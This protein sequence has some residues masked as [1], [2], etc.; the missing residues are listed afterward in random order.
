MQLTEL[1]LFN[2]R[3]FPPQQRLALKPGYNAL[4]GAPAPLRAA[5]Y[6]CLYP[7]PQ[8]S[9]LAA[10]SGAR[11]GVE[12][13]GKDGKPY[14]MLR[15]LSGVGATLSREDPPGQWPTVAA[16][17]ASLVRELVQL[18]AVPPP[19]FVAL[20]NLGEE[21]L[22]S[23][24]PGGGDTAGLQKQIADLQRELALAN[25]VENFGDR[26]FALEKRIQEIDQLLSGLHGREQQLQR[27]DD[28]L[29]VF[30]RFAKGLDQKVK[31]YPQALKIKD[32]GLQEIADQQADLAKDL[33]RTVPP[34]WQDRIFMAGAAAGALP[35]VMALVAGKGWLFADIPGF[36]AAAVGAWL[37]IMKMEQYDVL[38]ARKKQ[39]EDRAHRVLQ[40]WDADAGPV[41]AA[42]HALQI[43]TVQELGEQLK[44]R[45]NL[46]IERDSGAVLLEG[47]RRAPEM[48][49]LADE[50]ASGKDELTRMEARMARAGF[51]R[52][53]AEI[54]QDLV[55]LQAELQAAYSS[56]PPPED[57]LL[58]ACASFFGIQ[59]AQLGQAAG[60]RAAQFR[61]G[62]APVTGGPDAR[63]L[64]Y[65]ALKAALLE[66]AAQ[67]SK[68]P[69]LIEGSFYGAE[70][71][72]KHLST[73]TQVIQL[74]SQAPAGAENVIRIG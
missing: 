54:E 12:F 39:L 10:S 21:E 32:D 65:V 70:K 74:A 17:P 23:R 16:D 57:A 45:D 37:W 33:A 64:G 27:L 58:A 52:G 66:R 31:R 50:R 73:Q 34:L 62:L 30:T 20:Y 43:S 71:L 35:V 13:K 40:N 56:G 4:V 24:R 1:L 18:G 22:P 48:Q 15:D 8:D 9:A 11:V 5:L 67:R 72:F 28:Q 41:V 7:G 25:E 69:F 19:L 36:T 55:N 51:A 2:I 53:S 38:V 29:A 47:M 44:Y 3:G 61:S 6:A 63:D 26:Q 49:G 59:A 68:L 42:M 46:Q 14:R 60:A